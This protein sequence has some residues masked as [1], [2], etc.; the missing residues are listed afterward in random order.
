MTS[1]LHLDGYISFTLAVLLLFVGKAFTRRFEMLRRYSIPEPVLGGV[2]C[3]G[4]VSAVYLAT[5]LKIDFQLGVRDVLL[6]YFFG[7]IGLGVRA[8]LGWY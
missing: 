3:I 1:E 6:L 7:A 5:G 4:I 8:L 2:V